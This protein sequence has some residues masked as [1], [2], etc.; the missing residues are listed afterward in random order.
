MADQPARAV[1]ASAHLT[2]R[3]PRDYALLV[4]WIS[5]DLGL[6]HAAFIRRCIEYFVATKVDPGL[7]EALADARSSALRA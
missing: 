7:A 1:K 6:T 3:L 5:R 4:T 2:L